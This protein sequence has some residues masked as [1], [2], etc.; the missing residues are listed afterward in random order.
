MAPL[1][2]LCLIFGGTLVSS[3]SK[4]ALYPSNVTDT[5]G[6]NAF[7]YPAQWLLDEQLIAGDPLNNPS[8]S[9][10][11]KNPWLPTYKADWYQSGN[12]SF[13]TPRAVIDLG[14]MYDITNICTYTTNP[15]WDVIWQVFKTNPFQNP[16]Q[17]L[18]TNI[19]YNWNGWACR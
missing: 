14:A 2:L 16:I 8:S 15:N 9:K 12:P 19:N 13:P 6:L 5:Y 1:S 7:G 17:S 18:K 11:C 3:V 4:I 10:P